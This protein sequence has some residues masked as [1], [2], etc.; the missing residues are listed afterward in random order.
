ML[1]CYEAFHAK[2]G[3]FDAQKFDVLGLDYEVAM[4][5]LRELERVRAVNCTFC[6][7]M[8][9]KAIECMTLINLNRK[10]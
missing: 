1:G 5:F 7:G 9:H 2:N 10:A 3:R 6:N 4:T 8:G